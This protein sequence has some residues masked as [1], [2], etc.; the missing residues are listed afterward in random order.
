MLAKADVH[1]L[2]YDD[3]ARAL[4][5]DPNDAAAL[6]GFVQGSEDH[7]ESGRVHWSA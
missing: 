5:L 7:P 2:A 3:Y 4:T 6:E 1:Q